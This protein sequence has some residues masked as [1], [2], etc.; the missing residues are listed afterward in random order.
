M[1]KLLFFLYITACFSAQAQQEN[2]YTQFMYNKLLVNPAFAGAREVTSVSALY[3]QQWVGFE[4]APVSQ[5]ISFD[6]P[7]LGK[8][9]GLGL[10]LHHHTIGAVNDNYMVNMDYSYS[11]VKTK[12]VNVKLGIGGTFRYYKLDLTNPLL[13]T[14]S[15]GADPAQ[16]TPND[17][18]YF[19]GNIG[20]G[21]YFTYKDFYVGLS[22]PN[23][24]RNKLGKDNGNTLRAESSPH[25]YGMVGGLFPITDNLDL[26]PALMVKY[27]ANSPFSADANISFV[28]KKKFTFGAS[29]RV[30]QSA[31]GESIDALLFYQITEKFGIGAAYDYGVS[32][33]A[34]YNKGSYE[35]LLR[36]DFNATEKDIITNPRFFF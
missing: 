6:S 32:E 17:Y 20:A 10:N 5:L 25:F 34:K 22:V 19:N 4:G 33:L 8:K 24:Y 7:I 12:D 36:Y 15:A 1:K 28:V 26:K 16:L 14:G 35:M 21:L 11:L 29:Y 9:L 13:T 30:G 2:Q 23:I 27:N 31:K 3:R 18:N